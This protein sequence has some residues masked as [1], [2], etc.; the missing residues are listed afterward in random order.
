MLY[1]L[2]VLV[3]VWREQRARGQESG[4]EWYP[5][6]VGFCSEIDGRHEIFGTGG[7]VILGLKRL[8]WAVVCRSF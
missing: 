2:Y 7:E 4:L 6:K 5:E 8:S 1:D 3:N